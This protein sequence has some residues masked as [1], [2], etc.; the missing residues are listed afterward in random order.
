M[1]CETL[2]LELYISKSNRRLTRLLCLPPAIYRD[3]RETSMSSA[4]GLTISPETWASHNAMMLEPL[5]TNDSEVRRCCKLLPLFL[6]GIL[7]AGSEPVPNL[8]PV[9]CTR[10]TGSKAAPTPSPFPPRRLIL[11]RVVAFQQQKNWLSFRKTAQSGTNSWLVYNQ[12]A[13]DGLSHEIYK[14]R[15]FYSFQ[16]PVYAFWAYMRLLFVSTCIDLI[17]RPALI[18]LET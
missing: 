17:D 4:N 6:Q 13:L 7:R 12:E 3:V 14:N 2:N 5:A 10:E 9:L 15:S 18:I 11:N 16:S 1:I 8:E